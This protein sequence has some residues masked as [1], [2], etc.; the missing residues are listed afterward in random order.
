M[1]RLNRVVERPHQEAGLTY[2]I[3]DSTHPGAG[4]GTGIS[5]D[6]SGKKSLVAVIVAEF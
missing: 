2:E 3:C 6:Y 4:A 1:R 5:D